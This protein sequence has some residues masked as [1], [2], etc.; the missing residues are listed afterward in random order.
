M[1]HKNDNTRCEHKSIACFTAKAALVDPVFLHAQGTWSCNDYYI[2]SHLPQV[3]RSL[4]QCLEWSTL[5]LSLTD[6]RK[7]SLHKLF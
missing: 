4:I 2:S 6:S 3:A 7:I 5:R 1:A